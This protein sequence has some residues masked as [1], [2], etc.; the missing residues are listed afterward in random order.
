MIHRASPCISRAGEGLAALVTIFELEIEE[1]F[2][3]DDAAA[4]AEHTAAE[5][6]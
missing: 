5:L 6:V 3:E 2:I 4:L 1:L